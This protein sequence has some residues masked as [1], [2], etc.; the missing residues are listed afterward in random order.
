L[1]LSVAAVQ[2]L[3]I[4][5]LPL[6]DAADLKCPWHRGI[7]FVISYFLCCNLLSELKVQDLVSGLVSTL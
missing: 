1:S 3:T 4:M 7:R 2:L 5:W 6:L